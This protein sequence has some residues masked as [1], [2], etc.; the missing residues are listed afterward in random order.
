MGLNHMMSRSVRS[1]TTFIRLFYG[2][3]LPP[4][5][6]VIGF[7]YNHF[8]LDN[9]LNFHWINMYKINKFDDLFVKSEKNIA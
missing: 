3:A 9:L 7:I 2:Q 1:L 8:R 5:N 4:M 6:G